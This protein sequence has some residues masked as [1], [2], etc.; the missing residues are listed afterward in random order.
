M[1]LLHPTM[2]ARKM[3]TMKA[4]TTPKQSPFK[5]FR[6]KHTRAAARAVMN[7]RMTWREAAERYGCGQASISRAIKTIKAERA[8]IAGAEAQAESAHA[9]A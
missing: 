5:G 8:K 6:S 3:H 9:G 4:Q 1:V 7:G 2:E